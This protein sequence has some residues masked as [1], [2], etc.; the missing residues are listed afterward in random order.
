MR[1]YKLLLLTLVTR[2]TP[3]HVQEAPLHPLVGKEKKTIS[4]SH[5]PQGE[6]TLGTMTFLPL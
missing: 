2:G 4:L 6:L 5:S 3:S 1:D